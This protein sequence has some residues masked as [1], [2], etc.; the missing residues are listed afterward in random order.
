MFYLET[1][2]TPNNQYVYTKFE[3]YGAHRFFPCF[4]QPDLKAPIT[5]NVYADTEA[6]ALK[7]AE[8]YMQSN[9]GEEL[10]DA[11]TT[12]TELK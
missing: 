2:T 1:A 7:A 11:E 4:D 6:N 9:Y 5:F 3:P 10:L 8:D 12:I